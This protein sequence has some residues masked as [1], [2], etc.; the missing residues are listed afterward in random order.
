MLLFMLDD[1]T[2]RVVSCVGRFTNT[3]HNPI[4]IEWDGSVSEMRALAIDYD[5]LLI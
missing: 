4:T 5:Q 1:L 2:T 3:P